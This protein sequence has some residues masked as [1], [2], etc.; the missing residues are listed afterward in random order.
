MCQ[1]AEPE[2]DCPL[3]CIIGHARAR[4]PAPGHRTCAK[5]AGPHRQGRGALALAGTDGGTRNRSALPIICL[6]GAI[7]LALVR[8]RPEPVKAG[9]FHDAGIAQQE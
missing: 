9:F 8:P 6:P 3:E 7:Q 1:V 2:G 5:L 4:T